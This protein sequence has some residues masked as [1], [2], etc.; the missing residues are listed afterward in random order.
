LV[1]P[2]DASELNVLVAEEKTS[3]QVPLAEAASFEP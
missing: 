2:I 1:V 3:R